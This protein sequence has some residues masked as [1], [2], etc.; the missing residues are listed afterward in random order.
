M[1]DLQDAPGIDE[2]VLSCFCVVAPR[3]G[4]QGWRRRCRG[5]GFRF[6]AQR[7]SLTSGRI[8]AAR[9]GHPRSTSQ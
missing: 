4:P 2:T 5:G 7:R 3:R 8:D 1:G 9:V 6:S